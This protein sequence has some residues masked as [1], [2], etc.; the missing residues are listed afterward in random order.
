[1]AWLATR[2]SLGH[3]VRRGH[4]LRLGLR[5]TDWLTQTGLHVAVG[6][7]SVAGIALLA[8][9]ADAAFLRSLA[10][11]VR[12]RRADAD[13]EPAREKPKED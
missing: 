10:A 2:W 7:L 12:H 11:M 13:E 3:L 6:V 4:H 1:M 8:F 9:L 5:D